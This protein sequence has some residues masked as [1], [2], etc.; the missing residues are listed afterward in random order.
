MIRTHQVTED[1]LTG[2]QVNKLAIV[3]NGGWL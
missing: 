2:L 3:F 1:L